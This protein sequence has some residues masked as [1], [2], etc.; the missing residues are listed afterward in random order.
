MAILPAWTATR[1]PT[2][3][4]TTGTASPARVAY[5]PWFDCD[6]KCNRWHIGA[7]V[8][9]RSDLSAVRFRARPGLHVT[10]ERLVD[11][12]TIAGAEDFV[13]FGID[14]ALVYGPW[15]IQAEYFSVDVDSSLAGDPSFSGYYVAGSYWLTGECR[16]WKH[17][18]FGRVSP[19]CDFLD[20]DCTCKGAW[21][22][23]VRYDY[24]D[25]N[26]GAI[27]GGEQ[28]LITLGVNWHLT[29]N[30]RIMANYIIG[31][32]EGGG[33][34]GVAG[35]EDFSAFGMRFQVD[36]VAHAAHSTLDRLAWIRCATSQIDT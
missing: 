6:C 15:S 21:E 36:W 30:A 12:G 20:K 3:G 4:R 13:G 18:N 25:L 29:P 17:A 8:T 26:D 34:V 14:T 11:T 22:V 24:L 10:D 35:D 9:S 31:N 33:A 7:S 28:S 32:V 2:S 23:A 27:N 16:N 19:C 1:A 5:T